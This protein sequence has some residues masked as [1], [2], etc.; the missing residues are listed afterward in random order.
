MPKYA[1]ILKELLSKKRK[2]EELSTIT[3][4]EECFDILQNK[5]PKKFK[6][7]RSCTLP[8][9]IGNLSIGKAL[10][11]LEASVNLMPYKLFKKLMLGKP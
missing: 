2:L 11:I 9:L 5:L 3:L 10:A 7:P 1:K 4:S 6:D 8:C